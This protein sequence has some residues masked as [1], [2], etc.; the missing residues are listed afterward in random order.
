MTESPK[1]LLRFVLPNLHPDT[2]VREGVFGAAYDLLDG[3][4]ISVADRQFLDEL[5]AWLE[6]NL[7]TPKRF[8][9]SKSI[10]SQKYGGD[11]LAQTCSVRASR[12]NACAG[13]NP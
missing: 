12:Q 10:R 8:N 6:T 3:N 5:L 1:T 9:R 7:A 11:F 13:R 2:G 4:V